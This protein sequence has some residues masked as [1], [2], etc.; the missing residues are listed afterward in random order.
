MLV[1]Q[2]SNTINLGALAGISKEDGV[3]VLTQGSGC[4]MDTEGLDMFVTERK[5]TRWVVKPKRVL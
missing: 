2:K 3:M 1:L 4:G 5:K